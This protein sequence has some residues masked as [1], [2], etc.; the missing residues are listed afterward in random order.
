MGEIGEEENPGG[1]ALA[2][3][4]FYR[5]MRSQQHILSVTYYS[6]LSVLLFRDVYL[7]T[8]FFICR[9]FRVPVKTGI[10]MN[11]LVVERIK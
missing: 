6:L 8:S 1:R 10:K 5:P 4:A 3:L 7:R 2:S 11:N 9:T